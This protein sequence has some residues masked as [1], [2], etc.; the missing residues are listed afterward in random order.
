MRYSGLFLLALWLILDALSELTHFHFFYEKQILMA[1]AFSSGIVLLLSVI[2]GRFGDI[3]LFLLGIWLILH[4]SIDLFHV[5]FP[6]DN[7]TLAVL[8][9]ASG[10]FIIIRK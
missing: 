6:Y 8:A 7:L 1:L 9:I 10:F 4:S 2:K 3:G 5:T